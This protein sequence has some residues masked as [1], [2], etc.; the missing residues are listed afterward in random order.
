M[1]VAENLTKW[2][3]LRSSFTERL[4]GGGERY[5]KAVD[6][7]SFNIKKGKLLQADY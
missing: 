7:I 3:D 5:V 2:F 4:F 1:I 6:D